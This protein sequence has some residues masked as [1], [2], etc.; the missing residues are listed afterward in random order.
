M[1][2]ASAR[3]CRSSS[4]FAARDARLAHPARDDGGV[5][6]HA[7]VRGQDALRLDQ[8]V[9]VVRASSPSGRG[10]PTRRPCRAPRR[11]PRRGRSRRTR[12]PATRSGP[13]AATSNSALGSSI[14]CSSWSSCPGS[15]RTTASSRV[16]RPSVA[17]VDRSL[18]RGRGG[19]LRRARLQDVELPVLDRELD[20]LHV[21]VVLLEPRHRLEQ[22][23]VRLRQALAHLLDRLRRADARD[24]VLALRVDEVLAVERR[25]RRST[26]RA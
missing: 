3:P 23:V 19:A 10:S 18:Q 21:A 12:R 20:V 26:G 11:C 6:G 9:D 16:M 22:L 1:R 4:A 2:D 5:R 8:P 17:H 25:A 14:G 7:A 13:R 15:M 24:D